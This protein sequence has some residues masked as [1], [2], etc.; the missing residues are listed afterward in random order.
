MCEVTV[1]ILIQDGILHAQFPEELGKDDATD[2][3][4]GIDTH[5]ELS[6]LDG[7]HVNQSQLQHA[8]HMA[9]IK[10]IVLDIMTQMVYIRIFEL[11]LLCHIKYDSTIGSRQELSLIVQQ[12][13]RIPLAGVM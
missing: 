7:I 10:G 6:R 2:T 13:Q 3:V 11:L 9:G 8:V 12:F 4:D 5:L 1:S